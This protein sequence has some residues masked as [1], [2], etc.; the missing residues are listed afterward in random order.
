M[1]LGSERKAVQ[2]ALVGY[3]EE[4]GWEY[5]PPEEA[6]R[7]RGGE[8]G[9]IFREIFREQLVKL[10]NGFFEP[11]YADDPIKKLEKL[12]SG[13]KGNLRIHFF[14]RLPPEPL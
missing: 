8:R 4:V 11:H 9:L 5:V 1:F 2:E 14:Q 13:I 10:N 3:A 7:L 12:P 6:L